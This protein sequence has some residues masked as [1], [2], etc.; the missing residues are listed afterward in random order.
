LVAIRNLV[1]FAAAAYM[2]LMANTIPVFRKIPFRHFAMTAARLGLMIW[3]LNFGIAASKNGYFDF[4][5]Y[6]RKSGFW[7][8]SKQ[9][10][11]YKAVD[12]LVHNKIKG[13]FYNDFDSGAY[14][15]GRA[16][17]DIKI[18]IDGRTELYGAD[19]FEDSQK[20]WKDGNAKA[21][22]YFERKDN[23]TGAFLGNAYQGVSRNALIMFQSFKNWSMVYLDDDAVIF[24]KQTPYNKPFI[25]R[26]SVNLKEWKPKPIDFLKLGKGHIDPF[27]FIRRAYILETLGADQAAI[28]ELKDALGVAPDYGP[29]YQSLGIIYDKLKDY[30]KAFEYR[31][32]G[33]MYAAR[34]R[35]HL[36]PGLKL[37]VISSIGR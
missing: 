17:P 32:L 11:P 34:G 4:D 33:D 21:F 3:M 9:A 37:K 28:T 16:Y 30:P 5:T 2:A 6:S 31:L 7:G 8:V 18:F 25:D 19:F 23:I 13:N 35:G 24:L 15:A 20:I 10:F 27:T 29:A 36:G 22:A 12:F 14:L 26:F 1:Y